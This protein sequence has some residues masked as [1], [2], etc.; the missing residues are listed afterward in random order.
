LPGRN[1]QFFYDTSF[2][3]EFGD[4]WEGLWG[5]AN[6]AL[7]K[8]DRIVVCGYS[9]LPVDERAC[10]LLLKRPLRGTPVEV[11]SGSQSERIA[12]DFKRAGFA[13]VKA[14]KGGYFR[15]WLNARA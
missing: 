11:I 5:Q 14:F 2:G 9:L 3:H 13:D 7:K 6:Q 1:K 8:C 15:E 4:F 10:N 12:N